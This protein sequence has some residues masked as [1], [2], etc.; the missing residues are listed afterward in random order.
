MDKLYC[1]S[2]S[3]DFEFEDSKENET[4]D[5]CPKC[6]NKHFCFPKGGG[7]TIKYRGICTGITSV[8]NNYTVFRTIL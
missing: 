1:T 3:C 7:S 6:G 5:M 4:I 2:I 8:N